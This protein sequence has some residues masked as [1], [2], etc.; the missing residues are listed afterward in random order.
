MTALLTPAEMGRADAATIA[1]G[2]PGLVLMERAGWAVARAARRFGPCRTLVLCGPGNN[3]GDGYVAA[4]L[5]ANAGW[6]VRVAALAPPR[7]GSDAALAA[8]AWHGP[9][10]AFDPRGGGAGGAGDRRRVRRGPV[11]AG[12]RAGR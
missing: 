12:G 11:G 9:S 6:P 2:V 8:A 5:L 3:G 7:A 1:G 4:R 10:A